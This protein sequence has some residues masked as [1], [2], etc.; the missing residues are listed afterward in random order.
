M[1]V[2]IYG[3]IKEIKGIELTYDTKTILLQ[4]ETETGTKE[5][6]NCPSQSPI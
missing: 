6:Y 2:K 5:L 1:Y 4:I 3:Q